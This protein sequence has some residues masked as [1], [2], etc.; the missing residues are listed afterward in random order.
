M[1]EGPILDR[2]RNACGYQKLQTLEL[3]FKN[4]NFIPVVNK[5]PLTIMINL[6]F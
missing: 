5:E 6:D 4:L 2:I 3:R 1:A